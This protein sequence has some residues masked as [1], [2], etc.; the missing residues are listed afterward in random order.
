M[1]K[2]FWGS[3][4]VVERDIKTSEGSRR[5]KAGKRGRCY[6]HHVFGYPLLPS[7]KK[8]INSRSDG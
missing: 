2:D 1:E 4:R 7:K 3:Q 8:Q 5:E 6:V